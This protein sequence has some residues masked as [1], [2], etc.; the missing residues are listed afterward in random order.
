MLKPAEFQSLVGLTKSGA[1]P[2]GS[3]RLFIAVQQ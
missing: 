3:V 1:L 2:F